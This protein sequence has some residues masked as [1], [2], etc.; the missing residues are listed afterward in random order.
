MENLLAPTRTDHGTLFSVTV[1][2]HYIECFAIQMVGEKFFYNHD[3]VFW[4][5]IGY[6]PIA[7]SVDTS[8]NIAHGFSMI[9]SSNWPRSGFTSPIPILS[10][11][12]LQTGSSGSK[13]ISMLERLKNT[14]AY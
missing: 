7:N 1:L 9:A 3:C 13:M 12:I 2:L 10:H 11:R 6:N 5:E 4:C 8:T 14:W